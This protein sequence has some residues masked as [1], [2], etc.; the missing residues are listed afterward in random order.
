MRAFVLLFTALIVILN[1]ITVSGFC[2]VNV[3]FCSEING[4][5]NHIEPN[6]VG[7]MNLGA[8]NDVPMSIVMPQG[9][10][11]CIMVYENENCSE[12]GKKRKITYDDKKC[13]NDLRTCEFAGIISSAKCC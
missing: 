10:G 3:K 2:G 5:G 12:N 9:Q 1:V 11:S 8:F 6:I 13:R 4:G 7:C